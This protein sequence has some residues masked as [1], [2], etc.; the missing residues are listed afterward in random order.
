[1]TAAAASM[2]EERPVCVLIAA[3]GGQGGGVL[4]DWLVAAARHDGFPAQ[5]TS[6]P[7]V[8]Q[9]TGA[10]T[11]YFELFPRRDP[12][13][14]PVFSL[15]PSSGDV[16]LL[17][18]LEPTEAGRALALGYVGRETTVVSAR[19]R[20]LSTAEKM[21]PGD[22]T[23]A[24]A[25]VLAALARAGKRLIE[26]DAPAESGPRIPGRLNAVLFG[27]IA[28]TGVLPLSPSAC[29]SA[30]E[31][32]GV[33]VAA[34]LAGFE[35]GVAVA[36]RPSAT[37]DAPPDGAVFDDAPA[38]FVREVADLPEPLRAIVGHGLARLVDYQDEAYAR[39]YLE[40]LTPII[41]LD[42]DPDHALAQAVARRLAAWMAFEDVIRVAQLKTRPGRLRRIR[43]EVG[44]AEDA[45]LT[46]VDFLKPGRE[47]ME[48]VLPP[49]AA[50]LLPPPKPGKAGTGVGL[51]INTASPAGFLAFRALAVLRP[52]RRRTLRYARE[53]A[54]IEIWLA[55]VAAAARR[56]PALAGDVA[57]AAV[58]ARGYG[59]VRSR[60]LRRL[61]AL[62]NDWERRLDDDPEAVRTAV[63]NAINDAHNN[64]DGEETS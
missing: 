47:E 40:R 44:G 31:H 32:A 39:L 15:Y 58:W 1:M 28:E 26:I 52:W 64:P 38:A 60:G 57:A 6:I 36:R 4:A 49:W 30:I 50:R 18:A 11:Y 35:A 13:K 56:D 48:G 54:A 51:R 8:A 34:N 61:H 59:E 33:A 24:A 53:Q 23:I 22:G 20:T 21:P 2:T 46:V 42:A 62:F 7:G 45:P 12:P 17:A 37:P 55:A 63:R 10:T 29:R 14:N 41:A 5:A 9:R 25:P 27:A 3:L 19:E 16:D 43:A